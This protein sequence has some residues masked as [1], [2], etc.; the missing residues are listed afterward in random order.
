[1]KQLQEITNAALQTH[2]VVLDDGTS[3]TFELYFVPMQRGW[4]IRN[5][6]YGDFVLNGFRVVNSPNI[7]FQYTGQ[8]PFGIACL[9]QEDREPMFIDDF[10]TLASQ[11]FILNAGE[12][13]QYREFLSGQS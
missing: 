6:T 1:M 12:L 10:E 8:L 3:V 7:L 9:S 13:E 11:L 4:F 5:L 2:T